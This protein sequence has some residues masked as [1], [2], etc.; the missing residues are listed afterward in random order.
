MREDN[1]AEISNESDFRDFFASENENEI[2]GGFAHCHFAS[3]DDLEPLLKELKVTVRCIPRDNNTDA[4]TCFYSGKP[5]E[6]KA[7]FAKAY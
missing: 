1:S 2:H 6:K 4:G 5:T 7:I 3:E